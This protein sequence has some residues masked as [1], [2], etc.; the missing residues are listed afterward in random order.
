MATPSTVVKRDAN[1][2]TAV[3]NLTAASIT[4][5]SG[6]LQ[7][8]G[9][10]V[11]CSNVPGSGNELTN[12]TYVDAAVAA[13]GGSDVEATADTTLK[14]TSDGSG[15]LNT[16]WTNRI[17][18]ADNSFTIIESTLFNTR[19]GPSSGS[20]L[21]PG[22]SSADGNSL[23]GR[24]SGYS[25]TTGK[26]NTAVGEYSMGSGTPLTGDSN[27]AYGSAS[28]NLLQGAA[29]RNSFTG[30]RS[31]RA[32]TTGTDN[33]AA[34]Y[35]S[36]SAGSTGT[37]SRCTAVGTSALLNNTADDIVAVGYQALSANTVAPRQTAVGYQALTNSVPSS[38]NG[39]NTALGW[40]AGSINTTG[41]GNTYVGAGAG[42]SGLGTLTNS[43]ALGAGA[44]VSASNEIRLGNTS[45]T[46][47]IT[48]GSITTNG[49]V[50]ANGSVGTSG[51][52]QTGLGQIMKGGATLL[53]G[54]IDT[55][56]GVGKNANASGAITNATAIG[57]GAVVTASNTIQLGN[58]SVTAVNTTGVITC[59]GVVGNASSATTAGTCTTVPA[60][61]GGAT[62]NGSTNV[63]TLTNSSVIG[64][65][66]TSYAAGAGTVS[67]ADSILGAIQKIDGNVGAPTSAATASTIAKRGASSEC[68][69]GQLTATRGILTNNL[70]MSNQSAN[71]VIALTDAGTTTDQTQ[72]N[73]MG[74]GTATN[75]LRT[76]LPS[77]SDSLRVYAATTS[78][79]STELLRV[80][81]SGTMSVFG[82]LSVSG[83]GQIGTLQCIT[84]GTVGGTLGVTGV[85]TASGGVTGNLTGTASTCTTVPALTGE[86]TTN[87]STNAVT[88]TTASVIGKPITGYVSGA[89]IVAATDTLLQFANK[90]SGNLAQVTSN[91][92]L[93][94]SGNTASTIVKRDGSGNFAAGT[95]TANLTGVAS[96]VANASVISKT[97]TLYA[98]G[99]G[100]VTSA[101]SI[102]TAIQKIDANS[103]GVSTATN[104]A[105]AK[106]DGSAG[107]AFNALTC[108]TLT[109]SGNVDVTGSTYVAGVLSTAGSFKAGQF[110]WAVPTTQGAYM[111][112]NRAV[113]SSGRTAFMNQQGAG[114]GGFEWLNYDGSNV[115]TSPNPAMTL[116]A[117][118]VLTTAGL[119]LPTTGGTAASLTHYEEYTYSTT[120]TGPFTSA[121]QT[122]LLVRVGRMITMTQTNP[123]N[124]SGTST[125]SLAFT[126]ATAL[127]TRFRP[128][129]FVQSVVN[130]FSPGY[131]L[132]TVIVDTTG[133]VSVTNGTYASSFPSSG[134]VGF[135]G[136]TIS[137]NV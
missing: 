28:G 134:T 80:A 78:S 33:L 75:I 51:T 86:A 79:A 120:F 60:L 13:G 46:D 22:S 76:Q 131:A 27:V 106:R 125:T 8:I 2:D 66:L 64:Q 112:W 69:F 9:T 31:G 65:A 88:L 1:G 93:P 95:I 102:L 44:V 137:W 45:V 41:T 55:C 63:V 19:T 105:V 16:V 113:G 67:S 103:G 21:V 6:T 104:N 43:M 81:G 116:D 74:F 126:S 47:V 7:L 94:G 91:L 117:S 39:N 3:N 36:L 115:L 23:Y 99:A 53:D 83:A 50:S 128:A 18:A 129:N 89:G 135:Q 49:G 35:N 26:Y 10:A 133:L 57:N 84:N 4:A 48:N 111:G 29:T 130:T 5:S 92:G 87:G 25:I 40:S 14:R 42:A 97:L 59:G 52:F 70:Y 109:A 38:L 108:T 98:A 71:K 30:A 37:F 62:T 101:D 90:T 17:R 56:I 119:K 107:C 110:I 77:T 100:T 34:G 15:K 12:K 121:S 82:T 20:Q 58:A 73:Y 85:L 72:H 24:A 32:V 122:F 54:N 127:P 61:S 136:F 118:G 68:A 132:G 96:D 11:S 114:A 123:V 124:V